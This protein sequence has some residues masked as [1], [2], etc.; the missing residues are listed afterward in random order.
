[1]NRKAFL[2]LITIFLITFIMGSF[3][4]G[5]RMTHTRGKK[6][7]SRLNAL[8]I[9][10]KKE[11]LHTLAYHELYKIDKCIKEGKYEDSIDFFAKSNDKKRVWMKKKDEA[12]HS[13]YGGYTLQK[14]LYNNSEEIYPSSTGEIYERI[15]D[16]LQSHFVEKRKFTAKMEKRVKSSELD[17][18]VIFIAVINIEYE[19]ENGDIN[20][21]DAEYVKEFVVSE[22]VQ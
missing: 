4:V 10:E 15:L 12:L 9:K 3:L 7:I 11:I 16:K 22:N 21:A 19:F 6:L 17:T 14:F 13:S 1:M 2:L 18:E 5:Y 20:R 8:K